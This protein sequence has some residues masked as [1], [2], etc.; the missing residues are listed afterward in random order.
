LD[1]R[2]HHNSGVPQQLDHLTLDAT[3]QDIKAVVDTLGISQACFIGHSWGTQ[4]LVRAYDLFPQMFSSMIAINGFVSNPV[5]GMFGTNLPAAAFEL[6]K[7]GHEQLPSTSG[8]LWKLFLDNPLAVWFTQATGGFNAQL[9]AIKDIEVYLKGVANIDVKVFVRLFESM[10]N[11]D[12]RS[13][14]ERIQCPTLIVAGEK[15]FVTPMKYQET[16]HKKIKGS[17]MTVV[18]MGSHC[19][20]LDMPEFINIRIEKFLNDNKY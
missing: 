3:V 6:L 17:E 12:G 15:D 2:G 18:P 9:T 10:M 13:V 11:Y 1:Y 14:L 20:Q 16:M 8:Y 7:K 4:L 5:A 19:S